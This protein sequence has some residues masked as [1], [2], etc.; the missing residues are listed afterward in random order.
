M[1]LSWEKEEGAGNGWVTTN[2]MARKRRLAPPQVAA[3][4]KEKRSK[5][6]EN[7]GTPTP[8][9]PQNPIPER[10]SFVQMKDNK[11]LNQSPICTYQ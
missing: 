9:H 11:H 2:P 3:G 6:E 7:S 1:V 10:G 4:A 8:P 5:G